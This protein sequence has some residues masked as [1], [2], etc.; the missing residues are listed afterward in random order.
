MLAVVETG[1]KQYLV[2]KDDKILVE[3]VERKAGEAFDL[4]EVLLFCDDEGRLQIGTPYVSNC[5]V[6]VTV[7]AEVKGKKVMTVKYKRRKNF[8]RTMGHRQQYTLLRVTGFTTASAK[9]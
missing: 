2:K 5:A 3:K 8:K 9:A 1:G 7:E 4:T 6:A